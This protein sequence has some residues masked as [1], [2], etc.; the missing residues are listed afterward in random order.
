MAQNAPNSNLHF[1]LQDIIGKSRTTGNTFFV[2]SGGAD[3]SDADGRDGRN[4]AKPFA[5][6]DFAIG[7]CTA[8][9]GDLI[10]VMPGHAETIATGTALAPDVA[11]VTIVGLGK[12]SFRPTFTMSAVASSIVL[13]AANVSLENF[14]FLIEHD[15][16]IAI[17]YTAADCSVINCEFRNRVAATARQFVNAID[18]GG[19]SG[20][21]CD[22]AVVR[23]CKF[24]APAIGSA[25]CVLIS[26]VTEGI[27]IEGCWCFGDFA[28]ACIQSAVIH[29]NCMV[30]NN[31]LKNTNSAEHALQF[32]TTSTGFLIENYYATDIAGAVGSVDMGACNSFECYATD[33]VDVSGLLAPVVAS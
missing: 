29:T 25:S 7:T 11:G 16:T 2:D 30:R 18:I 9:N 26:A 4:P 20:N 33:A 8:N 32:D 27:V 12:G 28:D 14:L 24:T 3:T 23:G 13:S 17:E 21:D 22:R 6:L 15:V 1:A 5:T 31:V 10:V 19:A